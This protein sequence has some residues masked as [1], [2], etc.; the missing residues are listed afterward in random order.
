MN[1]LERIPRVD[2][3]THPAYGTC[4]GKPSL[5]LRVRALKI[6]LP[7]FLKQA[8]KTLASRRRVI[9]SVTF[10]NSMLAHFPLLKSLA[11]EGIVGI[12]LNDEEVECIRAYVDP[13]IQSLANHKSCV[14]LKERKFSDKVRLVSQKKFVTFY[15]ELTRILEHYN[16]ISTAAI[17][18]G[19]P[20]AVTAVF[21]HISDPDDTDWRNRFTDIGLPDPKSVYMHFDSRI[22]RMKCLLY[23]TPVSKDNGPFCHVRGS[24]RLN[25]SFL[26]YVARKANDKSGLDHWD[27]ETR[28][29][30]S[31]LP[32]IFQHKSEFGNDVSDSDP[33]V[34]AMLASERE[35]TSDMA[36][37]LLFDTDSL[38]RGGMM[39]S[40]K[41]IML[42]IELEY[43]SSG[44]ADTSTMGM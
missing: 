6:F 17:Y 20:L 41:R 43:S 29:I 13:V 3:A 21:V 12:N 44:V 31:A 2:Y 18:R 28:K 30:F 25:A 36:N 15:Q 38:H 5:W 16:V 40:G 26:E 4:F 24:N 22:Q 23:L 37:L 27:P 19:R 39:K 10:E 35:Y 9:S 14:P 11:D 32:K 34:I 1:N 33:D 8:R 7:E 42:Q